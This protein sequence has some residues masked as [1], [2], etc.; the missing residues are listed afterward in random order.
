MCRE[1]PA[2]E[3]ASLR[4]SGAVLSGVS[5]GEEVLEGGRAG[6][7]EREDGADVHGVC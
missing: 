1:V 4:A 2:E 6:G 5:E 7:A 3:P